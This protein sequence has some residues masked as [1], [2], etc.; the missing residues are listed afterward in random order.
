MWAVCVCVLCMCV[1]VMYAVSVV[2]VVCYVCGM[3]VLR[4]RWVRGEGRKEEGGR[5]AWV[6]RGCDAGWKK[7]RTPRSMWGKT[8]NTPP[9][10]A[11]NPEVKTPRART[12]RAGRVMPGA[13]ALLLHAALDHL[14]PRPFRMVACTG[15][16]KAK[17]PWPSRVRPPHHAPNPSHCAPGKRSGPEVSWRC[18]TFCPRPKGCRAGGVGYPTWR[19]MIRFAGRILTKWAGRRSFFTTSFQNND[20]FARDVLR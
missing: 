3:C 4:A 10:R 2:C 12:C 11:A 7:T 18:R 8:S 20:G 19:R 16:P 13:A 15:A 1:C 6:R 9:C 5:R 17:P 14:L